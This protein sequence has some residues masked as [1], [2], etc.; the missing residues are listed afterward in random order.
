MASSRGSKPRQ[1]SPRQRSMRAHHGAS[2]SGAKP[3]A[4]SS[5]SRPARIAPQS[6]TIGTSTCTT[7]LMLP[8]SMSMWILRALRAELV[9]LA[10]HAVVEARAHAHHQVGLVHGLVGLQ[11]AVHAQHADELRV[12]RRERAQPHQRERARRVQ[13][14][15]SPRRPRTPR[16]RVDQPAAAVD[17]GRR[18]VESRSAARCIMARGGSGARL[19]RKARSGAG[20]SAD[21]G[22]GGWSWMSFG[23]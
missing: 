5:A 6:P 14:V 10:G 23:G 17:H 9:E 11:R 7:L 22:P 15:A 16:G 8:G 21:C 19:V 20:S 12:R 13:Q 18:A 4:G 3:S 2:R 1:S